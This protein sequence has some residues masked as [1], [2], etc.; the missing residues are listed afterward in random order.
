MIAEA[1][2]QIESTVQASLRPKVMQLPGEPPHVLHIAMPNGA[3]VRHEVT[4]H[5]RVVK[6]EL[7]DDLIALGRNHFDD[8]VQSANRMMI[9]YN[10]LFVELVFDHSTCRERAR[11]DLFVTSEHDF[12]SK[13]LNAPLIEVA[14]LRAALR[15]DLRAT[16]R[17][18]R[19]VEQVSKL[20]F[21]DTDTGS[22]NVQRGRES[23]GRSIEQQVAEPEDLPD[24]F[25]EFYVRKY[26]NADLDV[27]LPL[28]CALDPDT[29]TRRWFL[30]PLEDSW[31]EY[32]HKAL[33]V[34]GQR[35]REAF[36]DTGVR[37]Y[38]GSLGSR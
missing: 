17:G 13:R 18:D 27:R 31:I 16:Y 12:F 7:L 34:I 38:Q 20:E 32:E 21:R 22:V 9:V 4:P 15:H 6:L 1:I 35:L 37:V 14:E 3:L 26:A 36:A 25:Q 5:P 24:P 10:S 29:K 23:L 33:D 19:L 28:Q 30:K 11:L 2:K 8:S